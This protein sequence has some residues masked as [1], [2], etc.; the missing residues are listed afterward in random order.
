ML[1][2]LFSLIKTPI[3][4]SS[5]VEALLKILFFNFIYLLFC[6]PTENFEPLLWEQPYLLDFNHYVLLSI[7]YT[8]VV[9]N[10]IMRLFLKAQQDTQGGLTQETFDF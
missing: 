5:Y 4:F 9:R 10:L 7:F 3:D 1:F 8:M 2:S 6:R